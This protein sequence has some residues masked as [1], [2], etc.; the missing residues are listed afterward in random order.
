MLKKLFF[1]LQGAALILA[2]V[3]GCSSA[4]PGAAREPAAAA[5]P[6]DGRI[7]P[8]FIKVELPRVIKPAEQM[9]LIQLSQIMDSKKLTKLQM[10][11]AMWQRSELYSSW[12]LDFLA[13][14]GLLGCFG[15][16][17][18]NADCYRDFGVIMYSYSK[19]IEAYD[20]L[21]AA[22][23]L[24]PRDMP[25]YFH[26]GMALYYG[27][28][29]KM[30]VDDLYK[31]YLSDRQDPYYQMWLFYA[32]NAV[33]PKNAK[34]KRLER[35]RMINV[36]E[37]LFGTKLLEVYLGVRTERD[38][39][40]HIFDGAKDYVER[41]ERLCEAYFYMGKLHLL[42]GEK[43]RAAD[44]FKLARTTNVNYFLEYNNALLELHMLDTANEYDDIGYDEKILNREEDGE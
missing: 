40:D 36:K 35:Y 8:A 12:G 11:A 16:D 33:D 19:F 28:R 9:K 26:R 21:D 18:Q 38:L 7:D 20:A 27:K 30:A 44:Y 31:V 1:V 6:E 37:L 13:S 22:I 41:N 43:T 17:S 42:N 3:A 2:A 5:A 14:L 15:A 4:G 23:E 10:S 29:E 39:W 24:N 25:S 32:E 34:E